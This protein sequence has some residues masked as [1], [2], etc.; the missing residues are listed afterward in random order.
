MLFLSHLFKILCV[1]VCVCDVCTYVYV[2][3]SAKLREQPQAWVLPFHLI[4]L[5]GF[6]TVGTKLTCWQASRDTPIS[7]LR[8]TGISDQCYQVQSYVGSGDLNAG[9]HS[10]AASTFTY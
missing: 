6:A 7:C 1:H 2:C 9:P 5:C 10:G 4:C 8:S 3:T